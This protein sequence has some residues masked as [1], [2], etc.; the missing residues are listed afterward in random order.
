MHNL[1][2]LGS[3]YDQSRFSG[4]LLLYV[5]DKMSSK[6]LNKHSISSEIE[7]IAVKFNQNKRKW[8]SFRSYPF[9][10]CINLQTKTSLSLC[11]HG[12]IMQR[13]ITDKKSS[14]YMHDSACRWFIVQKLK[15][16]KVILSIF[17]FLLMWE[18]VES[19]LV[20]E[21]KLFWVVKPYFLTDII[22]L[23]K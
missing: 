7:L 20:Y 1:G 14:F 15:Y 5:N 8:L 10:M 22:G 9:L 2:Q 6:S 16:F 19:L 4:R 18:N 21:N 13:G 17:E 12:T 11:K 3:K 23:R